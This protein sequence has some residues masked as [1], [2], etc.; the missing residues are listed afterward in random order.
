MVYQ[1]TFTSET[2][3][4]HEA[5]ERNMYYIELTKAANESIFYITC[6]PYEDWG[7]AFYLTNNS[8][9][10]RIKFNIMQAMF[11]CE[12]IDDLIDT[13]NELFKDGFKEI[14]INTESEC[15]GDC[16]HCKKHDEYLN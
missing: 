5:G 10:E 2:I 9:Y 11:D 14:M 15:D 13:L 3:M 6:H 12:T 4:F 1:G 8:D 16:E 7:Y